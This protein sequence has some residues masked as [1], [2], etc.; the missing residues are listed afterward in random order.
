MPDPAAA[1]EA[2]DAVPAKG[3]TALADLLNAGADKVHDAVRAKNPAALADLLTKDVALALVEV[4]N[5]RA[6]LA[7]TGDTAFNPE[8]A[9]D[10]EAL[11]LAEGLLAAPRK[12]GSVHRDQ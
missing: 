11:R 1:N 2:L 6:Y 3:R 8:A 7:R 12:R 4:L 10:Y 9:T 5:A